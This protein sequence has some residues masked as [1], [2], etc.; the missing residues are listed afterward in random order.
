MPPMMATLLIVWA[1]LFA[2]L[3]VLLIYRSTLVI[4][5]DDQLF[6]ADSEGYLKKEQDDVQRRMSK[7]APLVRI[8]QIGT[9]LVTV[10]ICGLWLWDAYQHF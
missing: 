5:E 9:G 2:L 8:A 4:H 7:I 6:L 1:A 3:I 10:L